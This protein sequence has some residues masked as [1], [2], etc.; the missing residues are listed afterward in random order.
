[1]FL[2]TFTLIFVKEKENTM[3]TTKNVSKMANTKNVSMW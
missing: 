1:M 3:A 2:K